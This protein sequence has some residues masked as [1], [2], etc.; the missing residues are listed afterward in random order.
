MLE[1]LASQRAKRTIEPGR[2]E[3]RTV[4]LLFEE[5]ELFIHPHLMRRLKAVLSTI[6]ERIDWQVIITTHSPF[7]VDVSRDPRALVIHRRSSPTSPPI[8]SQLSENIFAQGDRDEERDRL[9]A[10][11]DFHPSVCEAFFA[12]RALLV[13]GDTELAVFAGQPALCALARANNELMK[14]TTIVSCDGKWTIIPILRMLTSLGVPVRVIHD[15]DRK[16]RTDAELNADHRSE[17]HANARI[18]ALAGAQSVFAVADTFEDVLWEPAERPMSSKDKPFRAWKRVREL[19]AGQ[20][21][22]DQFPRLRDVV[23][24][25]FS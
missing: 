11:L 5:P 24:F 3:S 8:V 9:R 4:V 6:A 16:G 10:L 22:L 21:N 15:L 14:D 12:R 20:R 18:L 25:A 13:E 19:T 1:V 23:L 2:I 17:F 7:L